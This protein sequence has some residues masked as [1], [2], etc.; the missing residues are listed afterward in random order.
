MLC[1]SGMA[2]GAQRQKSVLLFYDERAGMRGNAVV[3]RTI[4]ESLNAAFNVDIDIRSESFE[5]PLT[6]DDY[7]VLL[8]WLQ[9]KYAGAHFDAVVVV[10][11]NALQ[12]ART[13][14]EELFRDTPIVFFGRAATLENWDPAIPVTGIVAP[15]FGSQ[16]K[17]TFQ[18]IR[19]LQP[20]LEQLFVVSGA[21]AT[22][23]A[24]E[25]AA[26]QV[27]PAVTG[28]LPTTYLAG[29][30]FDEV[31][32][33]LANLPKRSAVLFL[34]MNQDGAG[35]VLLKEDVLESLVKEAAAPVFSTSTIH[36]DTGIVGGTLINQ[37]TMAAET[38][39]LVIRLLR[40]ANIHDL[41]VRETTPLPTVN[42]KALTRFDIP[43][44]RLPRGTVVMYKEPSL[45]EQYK[46][47]IIGAIS[48]CLLETALIVAL[49]VHRARRR[50][51]ERAMRESQQLLQSTID[52]LDARVALLDEKATIVAVNEPWRTFVR[53]NGGDGKDVG[54]NYLKACE[55]TDTG[56]AQMVSG[57]IRG[58][59]SNE[60]AEFRGVYSWGHGPETSWFQVRIHKFHSDGAARLVV[61]H[62]NVTEIKK[63]YDTQQHLTGLLLRAQDDTRRRIAR[64]LHDVTVQD[65]AA[66]RADIARVQGMPQAANHDLPHVLEE[67][68]ALCDGV[69]KELRTLSYLLHPPMLDEAGLIPALQWFVRGFVE[70]S[71]VQVELL[72][73]EDIGRLGTDAET[74]LFRVVQEC[75]T[76]VHRH[77]GSKGAVIWV[78]KEEQTVRVQITDE[79]HGFLVPSDQD[80]PETAPAAGV[81]IMGMRQRLKQLGG[82]LEIESG[83]QGTTVNARITM[84]E[85]HDAPYPHR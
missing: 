67:S 77:S 4:R 3:D 36:L 68:A 40:G 58:L 48:L 83:S 45:W 76:N 64:D 70:R 29:L 8:Q 12:F 25:K 85:K 1:T 54:R 66:I 69:I 5:E 80:N 71:G 13:H 20:D 15:Q 72:I 53:S 49:L 10:G 73:M 75:L 18:F 52:A 19:A 81:G 63:A 43:E 62:E 28:H 55:R 47:Y 59:L 37:E 39:D 16:V 51:A 26:R 74:A 82:D 22:D 61:A 33:Q 21:S 7:P 35:R 14:H 31:R 30:P 2:I 27:L 84:S 46:R 78:T 23:R 41:A 60:L 44:H 11:S 79:G 34:T 42:W 50:R 32:R 17:S 6:K 65:V 24:W 9:R 56:E 57:G 38:A